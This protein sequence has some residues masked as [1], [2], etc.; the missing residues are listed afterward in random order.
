MKSA[1]ASWVR[2]GP[3]IP[4]EEFEGDRL[5]EPSGRTAQPRRSAGAS[6]AL[7]LPTYATCSGARAWRAPEGR[8]WSG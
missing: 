1:S 4:V 5:D 7:A 2:R 3:P 6:K 8:L